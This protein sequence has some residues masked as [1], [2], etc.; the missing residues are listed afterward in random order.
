L[1]IGPDLPEVD[2]LGQGGRKKNLGRHNLIGAP[3]VYMV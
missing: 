1:W 2:G 3:R